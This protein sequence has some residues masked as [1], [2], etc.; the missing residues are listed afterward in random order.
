MITIKRSKLPM[1]TLRVVSYNDEYAIVYNTKMKYNSGKV[2]ERYYKGQ[3]G[4][5][6]I[7]YN[8]LEEA[9]SKIS[10]L[11]NENCEERWVRVT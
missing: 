7:T 10:Y 1:K 6:I 11:Q 8:T 2:R 9:L 3:E 4:A 5:I